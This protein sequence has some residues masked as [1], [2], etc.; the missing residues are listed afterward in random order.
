[1]AVRD[2]FEVLAEAC[3]SNHEEILRYGSLEMQT[4]SRMLL[5]ALAAEILKR[6]QAKVPANDDEA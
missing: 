4:A 6:E 3:L 5:Y 2:E 1:M